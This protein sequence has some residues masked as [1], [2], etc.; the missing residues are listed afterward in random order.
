MKLLGEDLFP[1]RFLGFGLF[2]AWLFTA[3]LSPSPLFGSLYCVG[4]IPYELFELVLRCAV[5]I[6]ALLAAP[7]ITR[8]P[9]MYIFLAMGAASGTIATGL[10]LA[11]GES[12]VACS[13]GALLAAVA[14]VSLF[15][16]WMS[17][18]GSMKLG[19]TLVLLVM[20][21]G[22]GALIF[23]AT[24]LG[25]WR[26]LCAACL[27]FPP[28]SAG[29][30]LLS[31]NLAAKRGIGSLFQNSWNA[32]P[33]NGSASDS[34]SERG[35]QRIFKGSRAAIRMT[36]ALGC[37]SLV[38]A[39]FSS[40]GF[41]GALALPTGYLIEPICIVVLAGFFI[42]YAFL[43]KDISRPYPLYYAVAPLIGLGYA[44]LAIVP[45]MGIIG[46]GCI[47]MGY[48]LFEVL[49]LNDY[50]NIV[51]ANDS[52]LFS[53]MAVGRLAISCGMA[54]GWVAGC[55]GADW[56]VAIM[57]IGALMIVLVTGTLVFTDKTLGMLHSIADDRAISETSP[58]KPD[59]EIAA[60]AF[61]E[62][63]G[64]SK[65]ETEVFGYLISGRTTA[66]IAEVLFLA[67][68]TVRAHVYN[69][70]QKT[71]VHSKMELMDAFDAYWKELP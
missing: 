30:L 65:R 47:M 31:G 42:V 12:P 1:I 33:R 64:L 39:L 51:D 53:T 49:A 60:A 59:K 24:L 16:M 67:E 19:D 2:W 43:A 38:F 66:Y 10:L 13:F 7:L 61:A 22:V 28:L 54:V 71:G 9:G 69:I 63:S 68:S 11:A 29:T 70:Y 45:E 58:Q 3:G 23:L 62:Y 18:F 4:E 34:P 25:G 56:P 26:A 8:K 27:L 35:R 55:L 36:I 50:C 15:L 44:L 21:Y 6:V 41:S 46:S 32:A 52:S 37:Y 14:E 57:A 48:L 40:M 20:S 17:F 5:L